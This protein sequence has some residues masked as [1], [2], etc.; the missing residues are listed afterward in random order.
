MEYARLAMANDIE[1]RRIQL[2]QNFNLPVEKILGMTNRHTKLILLCTPNY[3]TGKLMI[4]EEIVHLAQCFDGIVAIDETFADYSRSTSLSGS[5]AEC[6]NLIITGTLAGAYAIA[7]ANMGYIIAQ[8]DIIRYIKFLLPAHAVPRPSLA[9]GID[10]LTRRRFDV[11]KWVK[12]TLEE[13]PKVMAAIMQLPFCRKVHPTDAN[14]FMAEVDN[15]TKL[16]AYLEQEGIR[17]ADCNEYSGCENCIGI[18]IGL[19]GENDRLLSALRKY[20]ERLAP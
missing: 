7:G 13:R 11:D 5:L 12:W 1:C 14:F 10:M 19:K 6:P 4:K 9:M 8:N 16:T 15:A 20:Q 2:T 17:V 3:P 18:T